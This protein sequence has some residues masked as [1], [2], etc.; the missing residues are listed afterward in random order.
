VYK[1]INPKKNITEKTNQAVARV[2]TH[3]NIAL[4]RKA[5][6]RPKAI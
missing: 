5:T 1:Y 4:P 2:A 6:R 3:G